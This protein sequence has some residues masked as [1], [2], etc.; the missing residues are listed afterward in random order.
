[1]ILYSLF[2]LPVEIF[3]QIRTELGI[4]IGYSSNELIQD[5]DFVGGASYDI[6]NSISY[7]IRT[8]F[9]LSDNWILTS[10]LIYI[11]TEVEISPAPLVPPLPSR[12]E[13][14]QTLYIP[15]NL[16]YLFTKRFYAGAGLLLNYQLTSNAFDELSGL[17]LSFGLGYNHPIKRLILSV[18][19]Q[20][21]IHGFQTFEENRS[22]SRFLEGGINL[23]ILYSL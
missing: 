19:P 15:V 17:G 1:M 5:Q 12:M 20:I 13:D 4:Q 21:N 10:G 18:N 11:N 16:N 6:T 22:N 7:G 3:S 2:L 9:Y 8:N 14:F 23:G